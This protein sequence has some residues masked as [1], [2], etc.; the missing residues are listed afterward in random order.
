[1][2][3]SFNLFRGAADGFRLC[4]HGSVQS[5]YRRTV[6]N[7]CRSNIVGFD[8]PDTQTLFKPLKPEILLNNIPRNNFLPHDEHTACPLQI[9]ISQFLLGM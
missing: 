2:R 7:V 6:M 5:K 9:T 4:Q 3:R 1:M 8:H